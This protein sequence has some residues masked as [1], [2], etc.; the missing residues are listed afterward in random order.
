MPDSPFPIE[1]SGDLTEFGLPFKEGRVE[2]DTDEFTE[3]GE[4]GKSEEASEEDLTPAHTPPD[5]PT[6]TPIEKEEEAEEEGEEPEG[7]EYDQLLVSVRDKYRPDAPAKEDSENA[8]L[9]QRLAVLESQ[10]RT[11]TPQPAPVG[12]P[13]PKQ[14]VVEEEEGIDYSDPAVQAALAQGFSDPRTLGSTLKALVTLEAKTLIKKELGSVREQVQNIQDSSKDYTERQEL[15]AQ[16][17]TGLQVAYNMGGLEAAI[18]R[19]AEDKREGS[20]LYQYLAMN[21]ELATTPNGIVTATLAVSRAVQKADEALEGDRPTVKKGPAPLATRRQTR[22]TKRGQKL[23][24]PKEEGTAEDAAKAD[25]LGAKRP[26]Q[27]VEFMR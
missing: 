25:I 17:A 5:E 14:E 7:D 13:A 19:E 9:K 26:S 1:R 12:R 23:I 6:H 15:S 4:E 11:Y 22:A 18:V 3:P 27:A 16:L 10:L 24:T 2:K 21:P 20:M 8:A